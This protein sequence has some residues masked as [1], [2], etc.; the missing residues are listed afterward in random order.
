LKVV[1]SPLVTQREFI[2]GPLKSSKNKFLWAIARKDIKA[3]SSQIVPGSV[4]CLV[5]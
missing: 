5:H 4:R 3:A 1:G 2:V